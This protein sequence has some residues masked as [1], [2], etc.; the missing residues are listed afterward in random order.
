[1]SKKYNWN[2]DEDG[3]IIPY[4]IDGIKY[5]YEI[6][7]DG[8]AVATEVSNNLKYADA[9]N[10]KIRKT[11]IEHYQYLIKQNSSNRDV[12]KF[13]KAVKDLSNKLL[14][15]IEKVEAIEDKLPLDSQYAYNL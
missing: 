7:D 10:Y 3:K 14:T 5:I 2:R 12:I 13:G 11:N 9:F 4:T 8:K 1:M 6:D 15:Y